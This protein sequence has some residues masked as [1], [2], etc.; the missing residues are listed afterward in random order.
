MNQTLVRCADP[1]ECSENHCSACKRRHVDQ[2]VGCAHCLAKARANHDRLVALRKD[3]REQAFEGS[4]RK[5]RAYAGQ[6]TP[7]GL[8]LLLTLPHANVEDRER[9]V[10]Y[11]TDHLGEEVEEETEGPWECLDRWAWQVREHLGLSTGGD[12]DTHL[13]WAARDWYAFPALARD[14][15]E[16]VQRLESLLYAGTRPER[17]QVPCPDCQT[18]MH[19]IIG[20][21][22]SSDAL[23]CPA[24]GCD[25]WM[26]LDQGGEHVRSLVIADHEAWVPLADAARVIGRSEQTLHT[27]TREGHV[28]TETDRHKRK[29]VWWPDVLREDA[30][31]PKRKRVA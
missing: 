6:G 22:E 21:A 18:R 2:T 26:P 9:V 16:Q 25:G 15:H 19:V 17:S 13:D 11:M 8:P 3:L 7:G 14:L 28:Q 12:V 30:A 29:Q 1:S 23:E 4:T 24:Y 5:G 10:Q 20:A 31:R 27:W